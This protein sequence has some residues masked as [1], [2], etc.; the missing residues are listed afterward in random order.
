MRGNKERNKPFKQKH[1]ED[2]LFTDIFDA[3]DDAIDFGWSWN[4]SIL[5]IY[6]GCLF[7]PFCLAL[8][9]KALNNIR[10]GERETTQNQDQAGL[11]V[12]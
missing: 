6:R 4:Y 2:R 9:E 7:V 11:Q 8:W 3:G 5:L 12:C 10:E 1:M